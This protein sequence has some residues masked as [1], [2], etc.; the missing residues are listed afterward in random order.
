MKS[1]QT[2][3][4]GPEKEADIIKEIAGSC[5]AVRIRVMNRIVSS[6]FDEALRPHGIKASQMNIL[7]AISAF[8][9]VT[10]K[11]LC[12]V[13][14]MDNSTLSRAVNRLI[15]K[16]FLISTPSGDGKIRDF[17]VTKEG[18]LKLK[19]VYPDWLKAQ[20][21]TE[22]VLGRNATENISSTGSKFLIEGMM[23]G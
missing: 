13:L 4:N 2:I 6:I 7:V 16:D 15:D 5:L 21:Q 10:S 23:E 18:L 8:G 9:P 1:K 22:N 3:K 20:E 14:H 11:Q 17:Q 19:S 12:K